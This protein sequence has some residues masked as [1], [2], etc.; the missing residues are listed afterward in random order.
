ME[1][2]VNYLNVGPGKKFIDA[3]VGGGGHTEAILLAGGEV[4]GI[5]QDP[6]S[7][8]KA[9]ERL[10]ACPGTISLHKRSL[11][12]FDRTLQKR[13]KLVCSN[14]ANLKQV[15][16]ENGLS[17]VDGILFDLGFASFQM[18]DP[19]YGLSLAKEGPLDMRLD[20]TLGVTAADLVN[21]LP[22][23][24]LYELFRDIGEEPRARQ[25]ARAIAKRRLSAPFKSTTDLAH[26]IEDY[27]FPYEGKSERLESKGTKIHPATRVFMALR[28]AVNTE[29]DN[30][31]RALPQAVELLGNSGR[32]VVI[33][34]HSG[35][36]RIVKQFLRDYN[37]RGVLKI[38]TEKVVRPNQNE[39]EDNPR[40][41]SAKLRAAE[42]I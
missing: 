30:L 11:T 7:L 5:D 38:L 37:R 32:L 12:T 40:A 18:E 26:L 20:P 8:K 28:I 35:E 25:I 39:I 13:F 4:L 16:S 15:A 17:R 27:S 19:K 14:F 24:S 21:S 3:T 6:T 9:E 22:E 42:I 34:F 31:R 36:D 23:R 1:E 29:L 10:L 33:S 2:T 41:R